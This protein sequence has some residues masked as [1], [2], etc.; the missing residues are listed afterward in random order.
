MIQYDIK[1]LIALNDPK[2][3]KKPYFYGRIKLRP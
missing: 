1:L 2:A 3:V